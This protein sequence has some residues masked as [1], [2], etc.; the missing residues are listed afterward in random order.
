SNGVL[1]VKQA[2]VQPVVGALDIDV[3]G[4]APAVAELAS[5]DPINAMRYVG[6]VPDDFTGQVSGNVK[7][8]IPLQKG[9][10]RDRLNWLV[11]LDYEG[12][13]IA[14]PIDGQLGT[15]AE[16]TISVEKTKAVIAAKARLSG[17]SAEIAAVE[18][19]GTSDVERKRTITLV[20]DE[21]TREQL[22]PGLDAMVKGPV[23]VA[24]DSQA[25]GGQLV[26]ADL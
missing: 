18:P 20:L 14:R 2:N 4:E 17:V 5:Y 3:A 10:D 12:L 1:V 23:K 9:V 7:A 26:T 21:K 19:L 11:A 15:E 25:G 24:L 16:G 22:V 8:D 13:S 6:L